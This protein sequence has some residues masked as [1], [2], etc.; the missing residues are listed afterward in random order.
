[1]HTPIQ[2]VEFWHSNISFTGIY[3]KETESYTSGNRQQQRQISN[4]AVVA[5]HLSLGN[6]T[7]LEKSAIE[8]VP[9]RRQ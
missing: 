8:P 9:W 3:A 2:R 1:M 5:R 7:F 6:Y 4:N